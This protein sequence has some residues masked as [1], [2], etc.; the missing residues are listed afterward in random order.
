MTMA[1]SYTKGLSGISLYAEENIVEAAN[2]VL[3]SPSSSLPLLLL[4]VVF[5]FLNLLQQGSTL[6][7]I[8]GVRQ[9]MY[10]KP[11]V[12]SGSR[13]RD[14]QASIHLFLLRYTILCFAPLP[15]F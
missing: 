3:H 8:N 14:V 1:P 7:I 9:I 11:N 13:E 15:P 2:K 10:G 5:F 4:L 6:F 12:F